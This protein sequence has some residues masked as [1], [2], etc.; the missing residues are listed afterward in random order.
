MFRRADLTA[1]GIPRPEIDELCRG[2]Q[3]IRRGVYVPAAESDQLYSLRCEAALAAVRQGAALAG[4]SAALYWDLPVM[5]APREIFLRGI[6]RG[7]HAG[8]VRALH[9]EADY[10]LHRG[11]LVT[12]P[13]WTVVD[14]A[15]M[16]SRRDG[17]IVAD[18]VLHE[19][20]C[21]TADLEETLAAAGP[22]H[23]IARARWIVANADP[24]SESPGETWTRMVVR[25][26][27]Y[28]VTSQFR[29]RTDDGYA[30]IDLL[31]DDSRVGLE[32]DGRIKYRGRHPGQAEHRIVRE[33]VRQ[34]RLEEIG[35]QLLRVVW[36]QLSAP[37]SVD[38]RLRAAGVVPV[39][40]PRPVP[41]WPL[42]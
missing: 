18:A 9:G 8:G 7:R 16:L 35:Y 29:V 26:L 4:P 20:L 23:R 3:I 14:S 24:L 38:R 19:G 33:K 13:A 30:D 36:E 5:E 17:L 28:E 11:V 39:H 2:A 15:R 12:T 40:R 21:S 34:G 41:Q 37:D 32:F 27:G 6:S 25:D 42:R 10:V 1:A 22:I 31:I